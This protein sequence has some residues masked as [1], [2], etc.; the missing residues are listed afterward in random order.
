VIGE[1]MAMAQPLATE[2]KVQLV[3]DFTSPLPPVRADRTRLIQVMTNLLSNATKFNRPDGE[4]RV[5]VL[6]TPDGQVAVQVQDTGLGMSPAQVN[7]LFQPFNRLGRERLGIPGTGI[8]L[9]LVRHLVEQMGGT[10]EVDSTE[11]AGTTFTVTLPADGPVAE[12]PGR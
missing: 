4:V 11:G 7:Q 1:A 5:K 2:H 12:D 10:I 8:G 3:S 9:V 6:P